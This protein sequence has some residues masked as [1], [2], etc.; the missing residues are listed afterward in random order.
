MITA[1]DGK[2]AA[3]NELS[4]AGSIGGQDSAS[5]EGGDDIPMW[6]KRSK[7]VGGLLDRITACDKN[8][9]FDIDIAQLELDEWPEELLIVAKVKIIIAFKNKLTHVPSLQDFRSLEHLDLSRNCLTSV[10]SIEFFHLVKLK[11]LDISRNK[12]AKLPDDLTKCP[13]L[14]KLIIHRNQLVEF[15]AE[16][17][18][19][20]RLRYIDASYNNIRHVGLELETL[21]HLEE[22]NL[23]HND[24][25]D[26]GNMGLGEMGPK[27][28]QLC[29]KRGLLASKQE[30]RALITR[31]LGLQKKILLKEQQAVM[32]ELRMN[33]EKESKER[34]S[35]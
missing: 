29:D 17:A 2:A 25:L 11:H 23:S 16:M 14:E 20:R 19:L 13:V 31:A 15:P 9:Q 35:T 18:N 7:R 32:D 4:L 24:E 30:R 26:K 8:G 28:R 10:D 27:T 5:V 22:L 34:G 21:P 3:E 6:K 1:G 33:E 12:I